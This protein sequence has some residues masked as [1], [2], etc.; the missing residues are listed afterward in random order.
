MAVTLADTLGKAAAH[1]L[2]EQAARQALAQSR[3]LREVLQEMPD[4]SAQLSSTQL[5]ALFAPDSWRGMADT[6]INRVLAQR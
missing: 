3:H 6:W 4:V 1:A 5:A 2:V